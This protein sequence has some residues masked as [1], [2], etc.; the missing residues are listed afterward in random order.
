VDRGPPQRDG[1]MGFPDPGRPQQE[2]PI[3]IPD[4]AAERQFPEVFWVQG[5]LSR[6]IE[7]LQ[8]PNKGAL[9]ETSRPLPAPLFPAGDFDLTEEGQRLA[10]VQIPPGRLIEESVQL[11]AQRGELK[12]PESR[13]SVIVS[14]FHQPPPAGTAPAAAT[15]RDHAL[16][17]ASSAAHEAQVRP[18]M[19]WCLT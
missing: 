6:E 4:P 5:R 17:C 15:V 10:Q 14:G 7:V 11:I 12:T 8:G 3:P 19:A 16:R 18:A 2:D 9:R 1:E 13:V